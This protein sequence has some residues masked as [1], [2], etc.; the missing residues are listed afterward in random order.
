ML[1]LL[2]ASVVRARSSFALRAQRSP[3]SWSTTVAIRGRCTVPN[4]SDWLLHQFYLEKQK[5]PTASAGKAAVRSL[6]AHARFDGPTR[7]V[8]LRTAGANGK[9]YVDLGRANAITR[10][11]LADRSLIF[12]PPK[13]T[14]D[15]RVPEADFWPAFE[16]ERAAIF[17]ALLD[18]VAHGPKQLSGVRLSRLPRMADFAKWVS[19][20]RRPM[21]SQAL[22]WRRWLRAPRRRSRT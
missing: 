7:D 10:S 6:G 12:A 17:G 14:S 4:F 9:I 5:A 2:C 11:D 20:V 19:P 18:I 15:V 13:M 3:T 16:A 22:S 1:T 8:Y 21:L